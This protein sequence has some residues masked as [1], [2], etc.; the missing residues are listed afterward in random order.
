M[1]DS[2]IRLWEDAQS[3]ATNPR[4]TMEE[5]ERIVRQAAAR[6]KAMGREDLAIA[7]KGSMS[8]R[9]RHLSKLR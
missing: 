7:L 9:T 4:V 6:L 2:V 3:V 1:K 5:A 8:W